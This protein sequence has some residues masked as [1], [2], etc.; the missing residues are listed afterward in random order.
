MTLLTAKR[1][2]RR[3]VR[4]TSRNRHEYQK[5]MGTHGPTHGNT[6][7]SCTH[8][9]GLPIPTGS[10]EYG[11]GIWSWWVYSWVPTKLSV[12]YLHMVKDKKGHI[13][14]DNTSRE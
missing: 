6:R 5:L 4:G 7:E 13:F 2:T 8:G 1:S 14:I 12:M 9:Y 3:R 10:H 11:Y